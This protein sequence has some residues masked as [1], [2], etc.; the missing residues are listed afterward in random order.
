MEALKQQEIEVLRT[1]AQKYMSYATLPVQEEKRRLWTVLNDLHMEKP[2]VCIDQLPWNEL[3]VDGSLICQVEHPYYRNVEWER[4]SGYGV[5]RQVE[6]LNYDEKSNVSSQHFANLFPEPEDLE[7]IQTPQ[8]SVDLEG[9]QALL[10]EAE[11]IFAGIA[12]VRFGGITL[13]MGLWDT[14]TQ[15]M[16]VE[17]IYYELMDR[18]EFMHAMM[19]KMTNITLDVIGQINR[20]GLYDLNSHICHCSY[21]YD[22]KL[23]PA[24]C[25][26]A[27]PTTYDGWGFGL[28]QLFTSVSPAIT[29]EFEVPYMQ[30]L[31]PHFGAIYY[32]CCDR[33]DD[34][35]DIIARMPNIR[36]VSCSPWSDRE[37]FAEKLPKEY[38]MSNKPTPAL[39]AGSNF[40]EEAVRADLRRTMQAARENGL[41]LEMILKDV[42]TVRYDPQRLWRWAEIAMEETFRAADR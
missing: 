34:R 23:P 42:S 39:L 33:L 5:E 38:I 37:R 29:A 28:A 18:P 7:K 1:L 15:W 32:G 22:S 27:H 14:I 21:V 30:R 26:P 19:E 25:D 17:D 6:V 36:K 2:M 8:L 11:R 31:F 41:G 40:D 20:L 35:L 3:D 24:S 10:T 12:P 9:E 16:G 4:D 13:H